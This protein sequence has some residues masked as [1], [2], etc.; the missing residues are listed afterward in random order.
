MPSSNEFIDLRPENS[1]FLGHGLK[2]RQKI[3]NHVKNLRS[4]K[5]VISLIERCILRIWG[6]CSIM[7]SHA[8]ELPFDLLGGAVNVVTSRGGSGLTIVFYF[9]N[10]S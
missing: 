5:E 9:I 6:T 7:V 4:S 3:P 8:F 10:I 2:L 1:L